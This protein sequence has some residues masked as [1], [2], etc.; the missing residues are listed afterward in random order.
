M[1]ESAND[2]SDDSTVL[3]VLRAAAVFQPGA[4]GLYIAERFHA[5][6]AVI[7]SPA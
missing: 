7:E 6:I 5:A 2:F 1:S 4:G 3:H